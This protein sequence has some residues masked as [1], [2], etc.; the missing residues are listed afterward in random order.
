MT[1]SESTP[2]GERTC[3][4]CGEP[5]TMQP[6]VADMPCPHCGRFVNTVACP[7]CGQPMHVEE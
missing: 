2:E 4:H 5:Y 6:D 1:E 3:R 7:T